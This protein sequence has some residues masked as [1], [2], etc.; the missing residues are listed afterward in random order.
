MENYD[1]E[2]M[3]DAD[4]LNPTEVTPE[5]KSCKTCG[6]KGLGS[7]NTKIIVLGLAILFTSF[8]GVIKMVQDIYHLFTR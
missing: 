6:Q 8:Y 1:N 7:S 3:M 2:T 4:I 5:K